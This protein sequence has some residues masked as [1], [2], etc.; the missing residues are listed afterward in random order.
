MSAVYQCHVKQKKKVP[1][2]IFAVADDIYHNVVDCRRPQCCII[3]GE[4]GAGKTESSKFIIQ[5]LLTLT[6]SVEKELNLKIEQVWY[7]T[8][9]V[10]FPVHKLCASKGESSIRSIWKCTDRDEQ[11]QLSFWQIFRAGFYRGRRHFRR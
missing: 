3:S 4:S 1:P 2:H 8:Y 10:T 7:Y 9:I 5:H 11:Q 6:T